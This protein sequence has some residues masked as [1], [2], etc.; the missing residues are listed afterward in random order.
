MARDGFGQALRAEWTKLRS[1][2]RWML[3]MLSAIVLTVVFGLI[4]A[5][6]NKTE[7]NEHPDFVVGPDGQPVVD[8]FFFVHQ[9]LFGDGTISARVLTQAPSHEWA[10]AGVMIKA[11]DDE[12]IVVRRHDGHSGSW[13]TA[14]GELRHR[15]SRRGRWRTTLAQA[16]P[17]RARDHGARVD[18]RRHLANRRH[19]APRRIAGDRRGRAL[20]LVAAQGRSNAAVRHDQL[21]RAGDERQRHLRPG[22]RPR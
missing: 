1:V 19:G 15:P 21:G 4:A 18:R 8:E 14:A 17:L 7:V 11:D 5:A 9:P 6:G 20:R 22:Q 10:G 12:R 2:R 3:A 13:G 16:H